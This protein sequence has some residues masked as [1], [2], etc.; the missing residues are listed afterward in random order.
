MAGC[1][2]LACDVFYVSRNCRAIL[3]RSGWGSWNDEPT[4][5]F[6]SIPIARRRSSPQG[7]PR[8]PVAKLVTP[9]A[10]NVKMVPIS[11]RKLCVSRE[12]MPRNS[13]VSTPA[14]AFG[15]ARVRY[16][17]SSTENVTHEFSL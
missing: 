4:C 8:Q 11:L 10:Q 5:V 16:S 12:G 14:E 1:P 2:L 3:S 15:S 7:T 6:I 13:V 9:R 17:D